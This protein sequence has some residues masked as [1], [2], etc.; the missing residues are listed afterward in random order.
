MILLAVLEA[1]ESRCVIVLRR[2]EALI[3]PPAG[4]YASA[5]AELASQLGDA[6][7]ATV[8]RLRS[9][10]VFVRLH[11]TDSQVCCDEPA[12]RHRQRWRRLPPRQ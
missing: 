7:R 5:R 8:N 9:L 10:L 3:E 4:S 11:I 1:C 12:R 6:R 2:F